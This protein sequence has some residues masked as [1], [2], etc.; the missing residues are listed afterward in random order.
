MRP[1]DVMEDG[2]RR[3]GRRQAFSS[4]KT[5]EEYV[6]YDISYHIVAVKATLCI[7][8]C[9][10]TLSGGGDLYGGYEN[11]LKMLK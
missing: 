6:R 2:E 1:T 10:C 4:S 5:N 9:V 3:S 8:L 11:V 7:F